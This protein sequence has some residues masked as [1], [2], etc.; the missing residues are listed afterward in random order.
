M[1]KIRLD[2][3]LVQR[4]LVESRERGQRLIMAGEVLVNDRVAD[5]PG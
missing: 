1:A 5:K 4:G 2:Q 3:L